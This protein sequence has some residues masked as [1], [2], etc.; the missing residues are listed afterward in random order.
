MSSAVLF[1]IPRREGHQDRPLPR[2]SLLFLTRQ[3]DLSP[4]EFVVPFCN[5]GGTLSLG[6]N[7]S[8]GGCRVHARAALSRARAQADQ[9]LTFVRSA[10]IAYGSGRR[11]FVADTAGKRSPGW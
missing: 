8:R 9:R 2:R 4:Y 6:A 10:E 7:S 1:S 3:P 5:A 11:L